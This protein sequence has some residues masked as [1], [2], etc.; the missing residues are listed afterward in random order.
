MERSKKSSWSAF[1]RE[2]GKRSLRLWAETWL[3]EMKVE[4][5]AALMDGHRKEEKF[6]VVWMMFSQD[7]LGHS[8][9]RFG[10]F[11]P[12]DSAF[13]YCWRRQEKRAAPSRPIMMKTL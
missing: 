13:E 4:A 8:V 10:I 5:D 1:R 9:T 7:R 3:V 2:G 6:Q 12:H 11:T